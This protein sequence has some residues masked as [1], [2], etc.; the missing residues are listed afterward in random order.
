MLICFILLSSLGKK[1]KEAYEMPL[2]S[3]CLCIHP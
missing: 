1:Y 2:L 3:V